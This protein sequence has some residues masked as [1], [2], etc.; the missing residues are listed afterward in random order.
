MGDAKMY[1]RS[2]WRVL[3]SRFNILR[4]CCQMRQIKPDFFGTKFVV[5]YWDAKHENRKC[6]PQHEAL[7]PFSIGLAFP[8][9]TIAVPEPF[10]LPTVENW[11]PVG[12]YVMAP[13][14]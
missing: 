14:S 3:G 1:V 8:T 13:R 9:V 4:S 10:L 12:G 11:Y 7:T 5:K 6:Y 2:L